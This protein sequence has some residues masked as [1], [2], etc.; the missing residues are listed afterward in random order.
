MSGGKGGST[1]SE[2]KVPKY[3]EEGAKRN[4]ATAERLAQLD[5]MPSYGP[6]VA[7][8]TPQQVAS[9]QGANQ[10]A[11]AFGMPTADISLP[12]SQDFG[13]IHAYSGGGIYDLALQELQ[14]RNPQQFRARQNLFGNPQAQQQA[15]MP[16]AAQPG[17]FSFSDFMNRK[18]MH[19]RSHNSWE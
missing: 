19:K 17:Q 9:W 11:G 5:Y 7:A 2:V 18:I 16:P 8:A 10:A 12:Q 4:R 14:R 13:G 3:I 1:S 15:Q 6:D